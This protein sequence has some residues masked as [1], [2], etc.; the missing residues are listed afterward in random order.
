MYAVQ[1]DCKWS[2]QDGGNLRV[3]GSLRS[4]PYNAEMWE[5]SHFTGLRPGRTQDEAGMEPAMSWSTHQLSWVSADEFPKCCCPSQQKEQR[6]EVSCRFC[7]LWGFPAARTLGGGGASAS[8][9][10]AFLQPKL[11]KVTLRLYTWTMRFNGSHLHSLKA[12][13]SPVRWPSLCCVYA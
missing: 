11:W 6:V 13:C 1:R 4:L 12:G 10:V 9:L 3:H 8:I 2:V 7:F 5:N